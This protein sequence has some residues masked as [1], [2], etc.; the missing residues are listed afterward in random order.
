MIAK[1]EWKGR[2]GVGLPAKFLYRFYIDWTNIVEEHHF[3]T[4]KCRFYATV[5]ME[6]NKMPPDYT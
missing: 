4:W 3:Y 6:T 2:R 1:P 5:A